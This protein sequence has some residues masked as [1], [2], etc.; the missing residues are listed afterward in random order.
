[1]KGT[2]VALPGAKISL[3]REVAEDGDKVRWYYVSAHL[4]L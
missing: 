2:T 1:M 3:G 4:N